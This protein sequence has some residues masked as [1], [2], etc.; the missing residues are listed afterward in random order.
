M[1]PLAQLTRCLV[2]G[3]LPLE[4][5]VHLRE[6]IFLK[7]FRMCPVTVTKLP[8]YS[9]ELLTMEIMLL[10]EKTCMCLAHVP[11]LQHLRVGAGNE[12]VI[13]LHAF[14]ALLSFAFQGKFESCHG[15]AAEEFSHAPAS[16]S[17]RWI[18]KGCIL[19]RFQKTTLQAYSG[20][21]DLSSMKVMVAVNGIETHH[22]YHPV[23][24]NSCPCC[25]REMN[26]S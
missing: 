20:E 5:L 26:V 8:A 15:P 17:I 7:C 3:E 16:N 21:K 23:W 13:D 4:A 24:N 1:H 18:K 2:D 12:V 6:A 10:P 22:F 14:P 25:T 9:K 11:R 19:P